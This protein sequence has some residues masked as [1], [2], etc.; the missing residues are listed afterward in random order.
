[1]WF[2]RVQTSHYTYKLSLLCEKG[3]NQEVKLLNKTKNIDKSKANT[4]LTGNR[5]W[6]QDSLN[7]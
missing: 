6:A 2:L 5:R 1:M 3:D 4:C 7:V